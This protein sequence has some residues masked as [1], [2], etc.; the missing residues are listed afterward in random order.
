[1]NKRNKFLTKLAL[2][3]LGIGLLLFAASR[4]LEFVQ[5]TMPADK[6]YMGYLFLLATGI[7]A[8]IWL[9][10]FLN[11]ADGFKQ[12]A[13]AFA[14]GL[15][16]LGGE[17]VLVYA[18]TIRTSSQNGLMHMAEGELQT[19]ILASVGAIALN[20]LAW[21]LFKLWDPKAERDSQARDLVDD[22]TEAAMKQMN[23]PEAKAQMIAEYA[24]VLQAAVMN[25]VAMTISQI[26]GQ[27]RRI[28]DSRLLPVDNSLHVPSNGY[29]LQEKAP[30]FFED[31][32][33]WF[34][35]KFRR[36]QSDGTQVNEQTV[37]Q[38][39]EIKPEETARLTESNNFEMVWDEK[40][41]GRMRIFCKVCEREGKEWFSDEPCEHVLSAT[42]PQPTTW[43]L[44]RPILLDLLP[45]R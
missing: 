33:R 9:A 31:P 28:V 38:V 6:Q 21:Y 30:S 4:T 41:T 14:M 39:Q 7:G 29:P 42:D 12:R 2:G 34:N 10:V 17:F 27:H 43:E 15:I 22:V 26:A 25:E 32:G 11:E 1:M 44:I 8:L 23:T 5:A 13:L 45:K 16:D 35:Q 37:Q 20:A 36:N 18:D 19:F 40:P 3:G 24:P